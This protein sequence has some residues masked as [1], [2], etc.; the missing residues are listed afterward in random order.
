V[1][2]FELATAVEETLSASIQNEVYF[3]DFAV[4]C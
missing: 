3:S 2:S 1:G 4:S